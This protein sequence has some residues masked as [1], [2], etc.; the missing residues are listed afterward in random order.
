MW[1]EERLNP[2]RRAIIPTKRQKVEGLASCT[3]WLVARQEYL[4]VLPQTKRALALSLSDRGVQE[5][6]VPRQRG[7]ATRRK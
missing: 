1:P 2:A 3:A 4:L 7:G 6:A 5:A